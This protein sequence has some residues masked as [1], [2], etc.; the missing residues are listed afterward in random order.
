[1]LALSRILIHQGSFCF[2]NIPG[3]H[4]AYSSPFSVDGEHDFGRCL[5]IHVEK[6]FKNLDNEIHRR[7]V[8]VK[9]N[10]L[11]HRRRLQGRLGFLDGE[12]VSVIVMLGWAILVGC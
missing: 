11:I 7:V 2:S 3:V 8:V 1:M 4:T 12:T 6:L 5:S 9:Q 10:H